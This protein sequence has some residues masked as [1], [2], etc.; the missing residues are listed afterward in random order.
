ML[1]KLPYS[2]SIDKPLK[3][4]MA[5]VQDLSASRIFFLVSLCVIITENLWAHFT[6]H[7]IFYK[8][9]RPIQNNEVQSA[10]IFIS[11]LSS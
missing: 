9:P 4:N 11:T 1:W 8:G 5:D 2:Y 7:E 3:P 10:A 6:L